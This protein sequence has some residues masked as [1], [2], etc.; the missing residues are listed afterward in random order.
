MWTIQIENKNIPIDYIISINLKQK[1]NQITE[2]D[3]HIEY[4]IKS[5]TSL[6]SFFSYPPNSIYGKEIKLN[7]INDNQIFF[8]TI[9]SVESFL[10]LDNANVKLSAKWK[11][12]ERLLNKKFRIF[13]CLNNKEDKK[14]SLKKVMQSINK[15]NQKDFF[16]ENYNHSKEYSLLLQWNIC[17][18]DFSKQLLRNDGLSFLPKNTL[19]YSIANS[20]SKQDEFNIKSENITTIIAKHCFNK[21][22]EVIE[23]CSDQIVMPGDYVNIDNP[24]ISNK[25]CEQ[26]EILYSQEFN[27]Q[28]NIIKITI[29]EPDD[30][31]I[32]NSV[33]YNSV[34]LPAIVT[35]REDP[36]K[37]GRVQLKF[38]E[39]AENALD[40][41]TKHWFSVITPSSGKKGKDDGFYLIPEKDEKVLVLF[42]IDLTEEDSPKQKAIVLGSI[43]QDT[44]IN[45]KDSQ[46]VII[47]TKNVLQRFTE[48]EFQILFSENENQHKN[49]KVWISF[50]NDEIILTNDNN[51]KKLLTINKQIQIQNDGTRMDLS[52]DKTDITSNNVDITASKIKMI[53]K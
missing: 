12:I 32:K 44:I 39:P 53:K 27:T 38:L 16:N 11:Y 17:D 35:S 23:Y 31:F 45:E 22:T 36:S 5:A 6:P 50:K 46:Y 26:S 19:D 14:F 24:K 18:W 42:Y 41:T 47:H 7:D 52:E 40:T 28:K 13:A 43:R 20:Q 10:I 4:S 1:I 15:K 2:L 3:V 25:I 48:N 49:M 51:D 8:G 30:I 9:I 37:K 33:D 21:K 29:C 34:L